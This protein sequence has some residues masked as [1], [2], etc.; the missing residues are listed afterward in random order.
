VCTS[1]RNCRERKKRCQGLFLGGR[2]LVMRANNDAIVS[3][4]AGRRGSGALMPAVLVPR[5][6]RALR[7]A[8][9][10][11]ST[12]GRRIN[13]RSPTGNRRMAT[14]NRPTVDRRSDGP[15]GA[16]VLHPFSI[17]VENALGGDPA[18]S[19]TIPPTM[20]RAPPCRQKNPARAPCGRAP[21]GRR[22]D[23]HIR[24]PQVIKASGLTR[25]CPQR[26]AGEKVSAAVLAGQADWVRAMASG[27]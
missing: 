17:G 16:D 10:P 18:V 19:V 11:G 5:V 25:G 15:C 3:F 20:P 12:D 23:S 22:T 2:L 7:V 27:P 14:Q 1:R 24:T 26:T 4:G 9:R 8:M 21:L 13:V 6:A